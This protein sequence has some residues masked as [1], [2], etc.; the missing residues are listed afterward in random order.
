MYVRRPFDIFSFYRI[1]IKMQHK[2]DFILVIFFFIVY[3]KCF[4]FLYV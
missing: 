3:D 4:V 1:S 2:F